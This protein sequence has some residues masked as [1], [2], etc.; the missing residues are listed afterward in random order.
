MVHHNVLVIPPAKVN[1]EVA[2]LPATVKPS[3]AAHCEYTEI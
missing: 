3:L 1:C 2:A